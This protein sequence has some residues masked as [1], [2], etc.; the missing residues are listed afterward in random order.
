MGEIVDFSDNQLSGEIPDF[1]GCQNLKRALFR[2]NLFRGEI[3]AFNKCSQV[4]VVS[5]H[6]NDLSGDMPSHWPTSLEHLKVN[7]NPRLTG[8][9]HPALMLQCASLD[10]SNCQQRW[11]NQLQRVNTRFM[12]GPFIVGVSF[13][14]ENLASLTRNMNALGIQKNMLISAK[15]DAW[16][17]RWLIGLRKLKDRHVIVLA[18]TKEFEAKFKRST[19]DEENEQMQFDARHGLPAGER[20]EC[21]L[22]WERMHVAICAQQNN[23]KIWF[24]GASAA[25]EERPMWYQL[26]KGFVQRQDGKGRCYYVWQRK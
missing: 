25:R 13:A 14:S 5:L 26:P 17:Q 18:G 1:S 15:V 3:P 24:A 11:N 16:Q 2:N 7:D 8:Q 12:A 6:T 21:I 4:T 23:L 19:S 10:Y 22:D 9:I 20:A